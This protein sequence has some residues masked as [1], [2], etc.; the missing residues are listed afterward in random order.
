MTRVHFID[1]TLRDG[2]QTLW[3]TRMTTSM[4]APVASRFDQAGFHTVDFLGGAVFDVCVRYL[5][6]NPWKRMKLMAELMPN[7]PT[8]VWTRG[9]SLWTFE[10][11]PDDIVALALQRIAANGVRHVTVYDALND[12]RNVE[13]SIMA[14]RNAELGVTGTIVYTLSPVHTDEYY[15]ARV[16]ELVDLEVDRVCIKDP[17]G[18]LTP[19]RT[20]T[21]VPAVKSA[22]GK[23]PL[24]IHSHTLSGLAPKVY[25][26]AIARGVTFL[27]T[28]IPPLA[29]GASLPPVG[30]IEEYAQQ[31][32]HTMHLDSDILEELTG[33]FTWLAYREQKPIGEP[34]K[35]NTAMYEHQ[36]PGGMI[37]NLRTQLQMANIEERLEEV[38]LEVG[39]VRKDLGYPI[40]VSPFAQFLITQAVLNVVQGERYRTIPDEIRKYALG[41]YGKVPGP[42]SD[43]FMERAIKDSDTFFEGRPGEHLPPGI[44]RVRKERGPFASEDD[45]LLAAFYDEKL[46][47]GIHPDGFG[48]TLYLS[49]TPLMELI[50]YLANRSERGRVKIKLR[51]LDLETAI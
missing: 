39:Q 38:L 17:S 32:G 15:V 30:E 33:Y 34:S 4:M 24:E 23:I 13:G 28:A 50:R 10:F 18:L 3:S 42:M 5:R 22:A 1:T 45:L 11:F 46:T 26:E 44:E 25:Q 49:T 21:L 36:V 40:M 20:S 6:E 48:D 8:N 27:Y 51:D 41:H 47:K 14:A 9:P 19:A 37:S 31:S 2:H 35:Y 29:H 16:Q 7:T 12:N 43:N